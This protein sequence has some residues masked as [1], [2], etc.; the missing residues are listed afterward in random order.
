MT[1]CFCIST[2]RQNISRTTPIKLGIPNFFRY[3]RILANKISPFLNAV[4]FPPWIGKDVA[5]SI[6]CLFCNILSV[7]IYWPS[8]ISF[9]STLLFIYV[10]WFFNALFILTVSLKTLQRPSE[11]TF[12]NSTALLLSTSNVC[13]TPIKAT[14]KTTSL[15]PPAFF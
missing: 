4:T 10:A 3:G 7:E 15:N 14:W 6:P 2:N 1:I 13:N 5:H 12:Q 11:K 8:E 9:V